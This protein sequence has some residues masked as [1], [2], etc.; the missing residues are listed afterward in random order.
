MEEKN[1]AQNPPQNNTP[2]VK[3]PVQPVENQTQVSK[4]ASKSKLPI[5]I[6]FLFAVILFSGAYYLLN[7]SK[8]TNQ[9]KQALL[10]PTTIQNSPTP[11]I[12]KTASPA[13]D[14][15]GANWKTYR[16][17]K[18]NYSFE[19]PIDFNIIKGPAGNL[20]D[21]AFENWDDISFESINKGRFN[22]SVNLKDANGNPIQCTTD[23]ECLQKWLNVLKIVPPDEIIHKLSIKVFGKERQGFEYIVKNKLYTQGFE[24]YVFIEKGNVWSIGLPGQTEQSKNDSK[25][26][27][28]QILSTFRFAN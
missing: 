12:D 21:S 8:N 3:Q 5:M 6:I 20:P 2:Q 24:Y 16:N 13:P 14:G 7:Q 26:T 17:T 27:F 15:V 4:P 18:Y 19:Y 9:Q 22:I 23:S 25:Q 1:V 11:T 10:I 28:D